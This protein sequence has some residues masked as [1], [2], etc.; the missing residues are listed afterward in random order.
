MLRDLISA[1]LLWGLLGLVCAQFQEGLSPDTAVERGTNC[2]GSLGDR[3]GCGGHSRG[4]ECLG[5]M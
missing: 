2:P 3:G 1:L 5:C 4:Q